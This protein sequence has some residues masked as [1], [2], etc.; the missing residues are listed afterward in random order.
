MNPYQDIREFKTQ[1]GE[2]FLQSEIDALLLK[3]PSINRKKFDDALYGV[4]CTVR[5][6]G[7]VYYHRDIIIALHCGIEGIDV[8]QDVWD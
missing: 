8:D 5:D 7:A 6:E 3:Y 2:G 1:Y 4:T